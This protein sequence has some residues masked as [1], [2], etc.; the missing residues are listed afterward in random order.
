MSYTEEQVGD[1]EEQLE[2]TNIASLGE[3]T[4]SPSWNIGRIV[5]IVKKT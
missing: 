1:I 2:T 3:S 5:A 4:P